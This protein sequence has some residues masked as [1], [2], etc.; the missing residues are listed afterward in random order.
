MEMERSRGFR[1]VERSGAEAM[2]LELR[3]I[4]STDFNIGPF[5]DVCATVGATAGSNIVSGDHSSG[6][7]LTITLSINGGVLNFS[8][9][10]CPLLQCLC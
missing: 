4:K 8:W 9:L 1:E 10:S 2:G 7:T 6:L 5:Y 3:S